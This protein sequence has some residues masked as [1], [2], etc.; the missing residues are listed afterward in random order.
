[1]GEAHRS[2][3]TTF[4]APGSASQRLEVTASLYQAHARWL[5]ATYVDLEFSG[6][7]RDWLPISASLHL[8]TDHAAELGGF[9]ANLSQIGEAEQAAQVQAYLSALTKE[10]S[11]D[12]HP[13]NHG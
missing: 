2:T 10:V 11:V 4:S 12:D 9:L 5:T 13:S 1:M 3:P 6:L 7:E 8:T